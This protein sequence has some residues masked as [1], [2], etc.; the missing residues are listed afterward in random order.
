LSERRV[1]V[2]A[3]AFSIFLSLVLT[4]PL[5]AQE[6]GPV[7]IASG[8]GTAFNKNMAGDLPLKEYEG[9][10]PVMIAAKVGSGAVIAAGTAGACGDGHWN[11]PTNPYPYFDE[12]LDAAFQWMKRGARYVLW[13][14]GYGVYFLASNCRN[15]LDN[16][17]GKGY[18]IAKDNRAFENIENLAAYDILVIPQMQLGDPG[19]TPSLLPDADVQAIVSFVRGGGGLFIMDQ[20][21]YGGRNF[22]KVHNKILEAL[23]LDIRFQ[24]DQVQDGTN[25]W[26]GQIYRPIIDVDTTTDIG[27]AYENMTGQEVIGLDSLCSLRIV[28]D[29]DVTVRVEV[30]IK[31]GK[32]GDTLTY[33][34]EI[35]NIGK[36]GDN[37]ILTVTDEL[38]WSPSV[39]PS[40]VTLENGENR[41]VEVRVTVPSLPEKVVNWI[42]LKAV[43]ASGAEDNTRFRAVNISPENEPPYPIVHPEMA[44]YGWS[45]PTLIVELPALPIIT[46]VETGYSED[47]TPRE[48]WPIPY[49]KGEFPPAAA[50]ALVGEGR[51]IASGTSWF[52]SAPVDWYPRV[53]RGYAPLFARW[54]IDWKDPREHKFLYFCTD[55]KPPILTFHS[56]DKVATWLNDLRELGFE[57]GIQEGGKITPELLE[58]YSVLQIAELKTPL[59]DDEKQAI[60]NWVRAGGGLYIGEQPDYGG[61][62]YSLNTN[63]VLEALGVPIRFQDDELYDTENWTHDGAWFPKIFLLDPREVNPEFDVWFPEIGLTIKMDPGVMTVENIQVFFSLTITNTGTKDSTYTVEVEETTSTPL[64]WD[65]EVK[66]AE[67]EIASGENT[68][69]CIA[70]TVPDIEAGRKRMNLRVTVTHSE[71]TY[72]TKSENFAIL[73]EDNRKPT[74][75]AKFEV[76]QKVSHVRWGEVTVEDIGWG[77]SAWA[78]TVETADGQLKLAAEEELVLEEGDSLWIIVAAVVIIVV[79]VAAVYFVLV[80]KR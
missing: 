18:S 58:N 45:L 77:G 71:Q 25:K 51:L 7:V 46:G 2:A 19:G 42:T 38:G 17:R 16:L 69:V 62:G 60:V 30:P 34:G 59:D 56:A 74:T 68:K 9:F 13:Y 6:G 28:K 24:D 79:V 73:G 33:R 36:K 11:E 72:V 5:N 40:A 50:A 23:D 41:Q 4:I 32:A 26:G 21:D 52:R 78:Y 64:G 53:A 22:S 55:P 37:Y 1:L 39:S 10:P 8:K 75:Q 49:G 67:V 63:E 43:G 61:Y 27:S 70:V 57:I 65:V 54:L 12:L 44:Y 35:I 76:G 15:L 29:Y 3:V 14:E 31:T 48:P 47:L 80:K 66:S 20:A